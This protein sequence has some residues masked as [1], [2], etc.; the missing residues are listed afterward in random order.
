[1]NSIE[2]PVLDG[3]YR[4]PESYDRH[5][6][7]DIGIGY[8]KLYSPDLHNSVPYSTHVHEDLKTEPDFETLT[9]GV[10]LLPFSVNQE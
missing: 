2:L 3:N 4:V 7:E 9:E 5:L 1:M 6:Q 8:K 10:H